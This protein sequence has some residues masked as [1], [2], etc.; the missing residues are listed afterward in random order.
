MLRRDGREGSTA[1]GSVGQSYPSV[2]R[3]SISRSTAALCKRPLKLSPEAILAAQGTMVLSG[4]TRRCQNRCNQSDSKM[5]QVIVH[6]MRN[7]HQPGRHSQNNKMQQHPPRRRRPGQQSRW[8][9]EGEEKTSCHR[10]RPTDHPRPVYT[11]ADRAGQAL[12]RRRVVE[13]QLSWIHVRD[14][15][16]SEGVCVSKSGKCIS[17]KSDRIISPVSLMRKRVHFAHYYTS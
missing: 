9:A 11:K 3:R 4:R 12:V 5:T 7:S 2:C 8:W 6:R 10:R 17:Y 15:G 13:C 14:H 16:G 1:R